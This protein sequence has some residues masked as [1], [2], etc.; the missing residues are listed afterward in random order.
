[1]LTPSRFC[2]IFNKIPHRVGKTSAPAFLKWSANTTKGKLLYV[3]C[4]R[5]KNKY[6]FVIG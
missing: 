6:Y 5:G 1:M 2:K 3:R 4:L